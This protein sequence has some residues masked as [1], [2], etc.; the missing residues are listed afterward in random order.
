MKRFIIAAVIMVHFGCSQHG[1]PEPQ[2]PPPALAGDLFSESRITVQDQ[3][4]GDETCVVDSNKPV[5]V[6]MQFEPKANNPIT[7]GSAA[8]VSIEKWVPKL[9][10]WVICDSKSAR[11]RNEPG[12]SGLRLN[13]ALNEKALLKPG[14]YMIRITTVKTGTTPVGTAW[15]QLN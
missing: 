13:A 2:A 10:R 15:L 7:D 9:G 11:I 8:V 6:S 4:L 3:D 1:I 14:K 5:V 12:T